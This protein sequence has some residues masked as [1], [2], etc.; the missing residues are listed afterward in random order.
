MDHWSDTLVHT[1]VVF[2]FLL[3][4]V[5]VPLL[6]LVF[7]GMKIAADDFA[8]VILVKPRQSLE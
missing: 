1:F 5:L 6:Q 7:N 8:Y 3:L 4:Q 2:L